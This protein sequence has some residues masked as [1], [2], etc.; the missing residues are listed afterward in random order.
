MAGSKCIEAETNEATDQSVGQKASLVDYVFDQL[1]EKQDQDYALCRAIANSIKEIEEKDDKS[2]ASLL[3]EVMKERFESI[4]E[5]E[6]M[7]AML[8]SAYED[9]RATGAAHE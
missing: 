4:R 3:L 1:L 8:R 6:S 9:G 7:R 2:M 5:L